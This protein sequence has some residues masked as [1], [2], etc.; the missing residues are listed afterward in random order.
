MLNEINNE[1]GNTTYAS[2][3]N[4]KI[5]VKSDMSDSKAV[6]RIN[7][8]GNEVWEHFYK[9]IVGKITSINVEENIFGETE[10]KIGLENEEKKGLLSFNIDSSY[11]RSFLSQI[12]NVD[13]DRLVIFEPWMKTFEENG[14]SIKKSRLYL[15]YNSKE[16]VKWE[17][18]EGTPE[19][20]WVETKKGKVIDSVSKAEHD[21]FLEEKLAAFIKE[22]NLVYVKVNIPEGIDIEPLTEEEKKQLVSPTKAQPKSKVNLKE[23]G[24][25]FFDAL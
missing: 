17:Y 5:V 7:K 18:P 15:S 22:N 1:T 11:G 21:A 13:L 14:Q 20:K 4:G 3:S 23:T 16:K 8:K 24:D 19:V 25:D 9:N 12:F 6:S 2:I 10:I